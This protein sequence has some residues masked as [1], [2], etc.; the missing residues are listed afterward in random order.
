VWENVNRFKSGMSKCVTAETLFKVVVLRL[1][2]GIDNLLGKSRVADAP[3]GED[4]NQEFN[5]SE[6]LELFASRE[7]PPRV[8]AEVE[9]LLIR[10]KWIGVVGGNRG[11]HEAH[12]K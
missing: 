8:G 2:K 7:G 9:R 1:G 5:L 11:V 10:G 12:P 3:D 6:H 4:A